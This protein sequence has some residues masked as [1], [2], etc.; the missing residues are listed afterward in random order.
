MWAGLQASLRM[1]VHEALHN[2]KILALGPAE[3][4]RRIAPA[5]THKLAREEPPG[6]GSQLGCNQ[7]A[8]ALLAGARVVMDEPAKQ[9]FT[10]A[11]EPPSACRIG[12]KLVIELTACSCAQKHSNLQH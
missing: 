10:L 12:I 4:V 7:H 9:L 1:D 8:V 2:I 6:I 5:C 11:V 3:D